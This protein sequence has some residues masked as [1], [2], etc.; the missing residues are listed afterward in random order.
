MGENDNDMVIGELRGTLNAL[1]KTVDA[2]SQ[3][4]AASRARVYV[5]LEEMA[6]AM[7]SVEEHVARVDDRVKKV[8]P[9]A[10]DVQKWK[11]RGIGAVML[12]G[13]ASGGIGVA[14]ALLWKTL[15]QK[16][17]IH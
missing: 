6:K 5:K 14:G 10:Q 9:I 8:E 1:I 13:F 17:G 11:E 15:M 7:Q 4:S 3:A 12:I 16:L 2:S